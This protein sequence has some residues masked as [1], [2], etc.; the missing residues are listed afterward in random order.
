MSDQRGGRWVDIKDIQHPG[1]YWFRWDPNDANSQPLEVFWEDGKL[2]ATFL[3]TEQP[4]A[5]RDCVGQVWVI[6]L[7][8]PPQQKEVET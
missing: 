5:L 3:G 2:F 7:Q 4:E 6:P 8:R 1:F